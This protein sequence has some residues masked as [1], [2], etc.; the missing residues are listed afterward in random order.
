MPDSGLNAQQYDTGDFP[1]GSV[2][3]TSL[4]KWGGVW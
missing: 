1:S 3:K 2:V 4:S